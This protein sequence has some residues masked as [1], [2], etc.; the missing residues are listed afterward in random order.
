LL[1][2]PAALGT[3]SKGPELRRARRRTPAGTRQPRQ[4]A[5]TAGE[6]SEMRLGGS[7]THRSERKDA[8]A[9][10]RRLRCKVEDLQPIKRAHAALQPGTLPLN[11][12]VSDGSPS[13]SIV[14]SR[15]NDEQRL[16]PEQEDC[17]RHNKARNEWQAA[18]VT[19]YFWSRRSFPAPARMSPTR[20]A[21]SEPARAP[22]GR[23][24]LGDSLQMHNI[25][26]T[27]QSGLEALR[28]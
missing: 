6:S 25:Q 1:N 8:D 12:A 21:S 26:H 19:P 27:H 17:M 13:E 9:S 16:H 10:S 20:R 14:R 18:T 2:A 11:Q 22:R 24:S 28:N 23:Y 4:A 7:K 3:R 5:R 15:K